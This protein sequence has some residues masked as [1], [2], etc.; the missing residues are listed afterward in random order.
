M[1][2]GNVEMVVALR[3]K[4]SQMMDICEKEKEN[5][6]LLMAQIA[7][8]QKEIENKDREIGTLK[9]LNQKLILATAFKSGGDA[10]EAKKRISNLVREIDKCVALLNR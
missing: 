5:A 2:D 8:L 10:Q 1:M 4:I 6:L 9:D 3:G 7:S